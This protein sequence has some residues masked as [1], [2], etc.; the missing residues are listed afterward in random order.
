MIARTHTQPVWN[1]MFSFDIVA[2][3]IANDFL[4]IMASCTHT[5]AR[6]HTHTNTHTHD[7]M[8]SAVCTQARTHALTHKR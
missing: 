2:D 1:E 8:A 4:E 5:R 6:A 7:I 3:M